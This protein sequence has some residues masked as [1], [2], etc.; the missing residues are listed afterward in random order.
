[1]GRLAAGRSGGR[2]GRGGALTGGIGAPLSRHKPDVGSEPARV[3][4]DL[5]EIAQISAPGPGVTRIAYSPDDVEV[6]AW[7]ERRCSE[8]G[9]RFEVDRFGNC[10][11]WAPGCD[12]W[13]SVLLGSHLDSVPKAGRYD[14]VL[15]VV[16]AFEVARSLLAR[17]PDA[18]VGVVSFACEESARFG[19]G[20]VGSRLLLGDLSE[21]AL[22][23]TRDLDGNVL[24]DVLATAR[25]DSS[26]RSSFDSDRI[27]C[28][29]EVHVDQGST[30]ADGSDV[31]IVTAIAGCVRIRVTWHGEAAHSGAHARS[32]RRN[33]LLAAA[34]FVVGAE[35]LWT[36]LETRDE[37]A[38]ITVG[39]I[40]NEPN[41]PSSVA[42]TTSVVVDLRAPDAA[43]LAAAMAELERRAQAAA[44]TSRCTVTTE[45]LGL[46][47]PVDM[48]QEL[49]EH[50]GVAA[51]AAG[52]G[53]RFLPSL[54]GHDAEILG[55]R[56]PT[57]MLFV[58]NPNAVS[59]SPEEAMDERSLAGALTLLDEVVPNVISTMTG[60]TR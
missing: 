7:F 16:V 58:A 5:E 23:T 2:S 18:P 31:G 47:Q 3:V 29:L 55:A 26:A 54:A 17:T 1:V 53:H 43:V 52:V 38:T 51:R 8:L 4:R 10:F 6:R 49:V 13:R 20:A 19:I 33:A 32:H 30:L 39:W 46:I 40:D 21:A 42:G 22:D 44:D 41:A 48:A 36:D 28:F 25:L 35:D 14:G 9:L 57:V 60:A 15:G 12:T 34:R 27:E 24:R 37:T 11:G 50:F 56:I 59:H 45:T